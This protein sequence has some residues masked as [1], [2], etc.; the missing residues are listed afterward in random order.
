MVEGNVSLDPGANSVARIMTLKQCQE[1]TC[2]TQIHLSNSR[3][4]E[5]SWALRP[6]WHH[7]D[8]SCDY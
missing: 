6:I 2:I 8:L 1:V 4:K 3:L 5:I 7:P